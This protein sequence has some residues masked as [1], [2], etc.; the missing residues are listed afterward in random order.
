MANVR[1]IKSKWLLRVLRL[2]LLLGLA[3]LIFNHINLPYFLST[4]KK[5]SVFHVILAVA[6]EW[7][8]YSLESIR[9]QYL[10]DRRY[11]FFDLFRS[12]I[13]SVFVGNVLPGVASSEILRIFLLDRKAPGKKIFIGSVFLINRIYGLLAL[14][15]V[16]GVS[17]KLSH[18]ANLRFPSFTSELAILL[19]FTPLLFSLRFLRKLFVGFLRTQRF[20][21][22]P[23][24]EVYLA[25]QHSLSFK[26][27]FL[28]IFSSVGTVA[29]SSLQLYLL[30]MACG[31]ILPF[32]D[33]VMTLGIVGV[34]STLPIGI[35]VIGS[36]DSGFVLVSHLMGQPMELMVVVSLL[37]HLT[38]VFGSLPGVFF[39]K[40]ISMFLANLTKFKKS[41]VV[42]TISDSKKEELAQII[43]IG[44][45]KYA[46]SRALEHVVPTIQETWKCLDLGTSHG[47][48][49]A[50]LAEKG[51]W[52][53]VDNDSRNIA[54]AKQFLTGNFI[55]T[56]ANF[57]LRQ[58]QKYDLIT[59]IDTVMYFKDVSDF[60]K[61]ISASLEQNGCFVISGVQEC[62]SSLLYRVRNKMKLNDA[63]GFV[64]NPTK[65][66]LEFIFQNE[67]L[68][69]LVQ[70]EY[71][72]FFAQC[73]QTLFD[74]VAK[75]KYS[76][77]VPDFSGKK[78]SLS[79]TLAHF[80]A[81]ITRL[82][83]I[84]DKIF[85]FLSRNGFFIVVQK[86]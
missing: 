63:R 5:V 53:F 57:F 33:W 13:L 19:V 60:I 82:V 50:N 34:S 56:D 64:S 37:L 30:G 28:T 74:F 81:L 58:G 23:L 78:I 3:L 11:S 52:T 32:L 40:D 65:Q 6:L 71:C 69:V 16:F 42:S 2:S 25:L 80:G 61:Q 75:R 86:H 48:L 31:L 77:L 51:H 22:K 36:Q 8:F 72:G 24:K 17:L 45:R 49:I 9:L 21:Q 84:L 10:A 62:P 7:V 41:Q 44:P 20:L 83:F 55:C 46:K 70:K 73:L 79:P 85:F 1:I 47:G 59:C 38:R 12:R 54:F 76:E 29:I 18:N 26:V 27:W 43:K 66:E 39:L 4:L 67:G 15:L 35:G 14:G 68:T